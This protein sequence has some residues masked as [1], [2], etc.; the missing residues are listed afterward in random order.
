MI[1]DWSVAAKACTAGAPSDVRRKRRPRCCIP[2]TDK[3]LVENTI[4]GPDQQNDALRS[5][6]TNATGD[7][8]RAIY[9]RGSH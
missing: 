6:A 7:S 4:V 5:V 3:T 2:G 1:I 8:D 9:S